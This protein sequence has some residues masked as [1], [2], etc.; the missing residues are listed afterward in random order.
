MIKAMREGVSYVN[1]LEKARQV[2]NEVD[3]QMADLF[4][5]RMN[6]AV[7][8][9]TYKK[10]N[11]LPI[12]DEKREKE[13][14]EKNIQKIKDRKLI[15]YYKEYLTELMN[16]SKKYQYA[17]L[18]Q[19]TYGYQ[20]SEGAFAQLALS[21]L[22]PEGK[23]KNYN[24]W[25][26]VVKGVLNH[27]IEKGILPFE[28]SYTGEVGEVLDLLLKYDVYIQDFYDLKVDQ[29]LLGIKGS[30]LQD[31]KTVYSHHQAL[32]QCADYLKPFHFECIPYPNTALAA[33]YVS[34]QKDKT[35]AAI[36]AKE[37]AQLYGLEILASE[38]NTS[39][40][41][42]TRFIVIGNELKQ[43]GNHVSML[44]TLEHVAGRL[45]QVIQVI[46]KYGYNMENIR[47][48]SL[49]KSSWEYYFYIAVEGEYD[50]NMQ[51]MLEECEAC[52]KNFKVIGITRR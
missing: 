30:T 48:R 35:I 18:N 17:L 13:V 14:I 20:G 34:E 24:T 12:F 26:E 52:C 42:T 2:I 38:I 28:N 49:K 41:N 40:D 8:V 23:Q 37:T 44:F 43:S 50:E 16:I 19:G 25:E 47:S 45:A 36:A 21:H 29:N 10:E 32:S 3:E 5:E 31:I 39:K 11:Q 15:P 4:Q 9:V 46:A 33:Q 7:D 27:E 22:F 51:A 1:Q 6:A